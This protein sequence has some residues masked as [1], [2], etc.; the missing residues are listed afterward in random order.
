MR[1]LETLKSQ[2]NPHFL[3]NVLNN[4]Y[5]H[6]L[7]K[8]DIAPS[9]VLKL[10]DLMS[11]IL[12]D[13]KTKVVPIQ[14]EIE[15]IRNY[16]ELEKIRIEKDIDVT[17]EYKNIDGILIPPLLFFPLIENSFKHGIGSNP[18]KREVFLK[19]EMHENELSFNI[20]NSKGNHQIMRQNKKRG[21]IGIKNVKKRLALLY[22]DTHVFQIVDKEGTFEVNVRIENINLMHYNG[23]KL[24][25]SR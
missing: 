8:T 15:F 3:F 20:K 2:L 1:G 19:L 14:K 5:S 12:Y 16:I 23:N 13:S 9:I 6:S 18:I 21:G 11:Y 10:S 17:F 25:D 7:L 22:P 24:S 4:I